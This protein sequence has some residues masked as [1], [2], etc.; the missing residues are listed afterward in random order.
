[1]KAK[2]EA[3]ET[4]ITSSEQEFLAHIVLPNDTTVGE[5]LLPQIEEAYLSSDMPRMLPGVAQD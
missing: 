3:T 1:M 4:G 2:L 5:Y